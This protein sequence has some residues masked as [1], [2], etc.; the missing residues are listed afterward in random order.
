[1]NKQKIACLWI[2][3]SEIGLAAVLRVLISY[4]VPQSAC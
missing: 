2:I 1:M 4:T 3:S